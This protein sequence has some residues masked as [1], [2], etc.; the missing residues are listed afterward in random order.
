MKKGTVW[1]TTFFALLLGLAGHPLK[2]D[3]IEIE[4][5]YVFNVFA[6]T[7]LT[8]TGSFYTISGEQTLVQSFTVTRHV[9]WN[10]IFL[11]LGGSGHFTF[12]ITDSNGRSL[13]PRSPRDDLGLYGPPYHCPD[14]VP[15]LAFLGPEVGY[16][17]GDVR[18]LDVGTT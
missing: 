1:G 8:S 16:Y 15:G 6:G 4:N 3:I 2:A 7:E 11:F 10:E 17:F 13:L 12:D 5:G 18:P 9:Q 14:Y